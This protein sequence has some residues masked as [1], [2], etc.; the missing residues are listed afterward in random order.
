MHKMWT[1]YPIVLGI[2]DFRL[3]LDPDTRRSEYEDVAR[4]SERYD[5]CNTFEQYMQE[6]IRATTPV[7]LVA[8]ELDYE[9]NWLARSEE[10]STRI[11]ALAQTMNWPHSNRTLLDIGCG[12]GALIA[13]L[14]AHYKRVVGVEYVLRYCL[15]ANRLLK[16]LSSNNYLVCCASADSLP[17]RDNSFDLVTAVDVIEHVADTSQLL[18]EMYRVTAR[19][20]LLY[21]TSPNR[22]N[23]F[24]PED[25]TRIY[26]VGFMPRRYAQSYVR[27]LTGGSFIGVKE[28]S[29]VALRRL[30][31]SLSGNYLIEGLMVQGNTSSRVKLLLGKW[32][33]VVKAI[34][35][36]CRWI[37][38]LYNVLVRKE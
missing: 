11:S 3:S 4:I 9:L 13:T 5:E 30:I 32:P 25:H 35:A 8:T 2:P 29:Y 38:P 20:G 36:V 27:I 33:F 28:L 21:L 12:K 26:W 24:M 18:R 23:V 16:Q 37:V 34:N 14:S 17:F 6:H 7:R 10:M 15:L 31:S 22:Y 1:I 19:R